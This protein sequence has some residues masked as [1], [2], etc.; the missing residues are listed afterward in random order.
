MSSPNPASSAARE[1]ARVS[2]LPAALSTLDPALQDQLAGCPTKEIDELERLHGFA[3]PAWYRAY[4]QALGRTVGVIRHYQDIDLSTKALRKWLARNKWRSSRYLLIG[5]SANESDFDAYVD[6]GED[7]EGVAV[8]A[9]EYPGGVALPTQILPLA[10]HFSTYI[11]AA[12][13][14]RVLSEMPASG[15][16]A[17]GMRPAGLL[18]KLGRQLAGCGAETHPLSGAWD[19][20]F[21]G[22]RVL[23]CGAELG[24]KQALSVSLGCM[25]VDEWWEIAGRLEHELGLKVIRS[26]G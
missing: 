11:F 3:L 24:D 13:S 10:S 1:L 4:L 15:R 7:G 18:P 2:S 12:Q 17:A 9:F 6:L 19:K 8:V 21:I 22:P 20:I 14:L 5:L 16:L 26:P 25:A 23:A